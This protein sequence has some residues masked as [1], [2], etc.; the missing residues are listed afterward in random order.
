MPLIAVLGLA[1]AYSAIAIADTLAMATGNRARE[2]GMLRLAGATPRQ[3]L[4]VIALEACLVTGV[5]VLLSTTLTAVT[6]AGLRADL[7]QARPSGARGRIM[8]GDLRNVCCL[9]DNRRD[10]QRGPA[11]IMFGRRPSDLAALGE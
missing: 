3:V 4:G 5:G 8:A 6:V 10:G 9:S 7:S 11:A 1:L 2:L